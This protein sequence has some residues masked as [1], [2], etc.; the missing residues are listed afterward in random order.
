MLTHSNHKSRSS[1][2]QIK[3]Q[4]S[5][6]EKEAVKTQEVLSTRRISCHACQLLYLANMMLVLL[7]RL[8]GM[9]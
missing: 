9:K 4:E 8:Q 1:D 5:T 6:D 7:K 2:I 3:L